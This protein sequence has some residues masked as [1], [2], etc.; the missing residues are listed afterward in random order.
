MV[1]PIGVV[2]GI[3]YAGRC[4]GSL[5]GGL[6][7]GRAR[8]KEPVIVVKKIDVHVH[9]IGSLGINVNPAKT[10]AQ[11]RKTGDLRGVLWVSGKV[12]KGRFDGHGWTCKC[13]LN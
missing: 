5:E 3:F 7:E 2:A 13:P 12:K 6:G 9:A 10:S 4:H 8:R 11:R 1:M